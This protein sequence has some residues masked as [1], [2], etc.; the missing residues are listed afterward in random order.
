MV[1]VGIVVADEAGEAD[2]VLLYTEMK[3]DSHRIAI[4]SYLLDVHPGNISQLRMRQQPKEQDR[5]ISY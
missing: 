5:T 3:S 2:E 1:Q 4:Q